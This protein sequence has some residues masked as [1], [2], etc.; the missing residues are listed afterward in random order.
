MI[1]RSLIHGKRRAEEM[2][3]A[4]RTASEAHVKPLMS[5]ATA[6][7]Q[8]WAYAQRGHMPAEALTS[9]NLAAMLDALIAAEAQ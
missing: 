4:A 5:Q 2:R 8:D 1:S 3:E 9:A 7:R 6:E